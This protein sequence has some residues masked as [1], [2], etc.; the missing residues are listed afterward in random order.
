MISQPPYQLRLHLSASAEAE[1]SGASED[2]EDVG[3][4]DFDGL[5][6]GRDHGQEEHSQEERGQEER[7]CDLEVLQGPGELPW[8]A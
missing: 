6:L 4:S 3:H 8:E 2:S 5:G 7:Y 1:E